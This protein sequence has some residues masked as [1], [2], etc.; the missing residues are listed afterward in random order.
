MNDGYS[1]MFTAVIKNK[2]RL[3]LHLNEAS[4]TTKRNEIEANNIP[5]QT[6]IRQSE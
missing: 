5:K 4:K 2:Q 3:R 1:T 6:K